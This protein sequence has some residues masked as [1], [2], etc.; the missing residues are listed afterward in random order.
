MALDLNPIL[1]E[2]LG[3][4]QNAALA[5]SGAD[6]TDD[7]LEACAMVTRWA[8]AEG[9]GRYPDIPAWLWTMQDAFHWLASA[10]GRLHGERAFWHDG[11]SNV[12]V[13]AHPVASNY[14]RVLEL[15]REDEYAAIAEW[16][17]RHSF[18]RRTLQTWG[19]THKP[20]AGPR[21][22]LVLTRRNNLSTR[23]YKVGSD[24]ARLLLQC[25][26]TRSV[27]ELETA[28]EAP[29]SIVR[30]L[31]QLRRLGMIRL[32]P[33]AAGSTPGTRSRGSSHGSHSA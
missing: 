16:A 11:A 28:A 26:G 4:D 30:G 8:S 9:P 18:T 10:Q 14:V 21:Q 19:I 33:A 1:T 22:C 3:N 17:R 32:S 6:S 12:T 29:K 5:E 31:E 24:V 23:I 25:D 7:P 27:G 15:P 2:L 13:D 20:D